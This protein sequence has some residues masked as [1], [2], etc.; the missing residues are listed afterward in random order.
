MSATTDRL[1]E[2]ERLRDG[3]PLP[4]PHLNGGELVYEPS[5]EP[6]WEDGE[7]I[8]RRSESSLKVLDWHALLAE[9][10]EP[11]PMLDEAIP[12]SKVGL[13]VL[14]GPP[15]VGKTLWASQAALTVDRTT[16]VVEEGSLAG[17]SWRLR[18]QAAAL[19][20][21]AP[22]LEVIHR[23]GIRL[24]DRHTVERLRRHV[25]ARRPRLL[26][27]DPLN[28]LHRADENRPT[29]MTPVMDALAAIA[30]DFDCAVLAVHH[31]AKPSQERRGDIWD[32][33]RG[34]TSIRSG[35][36]CNLVLDG[37]GELLHLVGEYRDAEPLNQ[38]VELDR[39]TLTFRPVEGPKAVTKV[40]PDALRAYVL[41]RGQATV[42]EVAERF[43]VVRHTARAAL[44]S[45][46]GIDSFEGPR[47]A[48]YYTFGTGQ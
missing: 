4:L 14:A 22:D 11:P 39:E 31:L 28:R 2:Y 38:Y 32:R 1:L 42:T 7:A 41:E 25:A 17:V 24:D 8:G 9:P 47:S 29:Q 3:D 36:D 13:T 34:A 20:V 5:P 10:P 37:S 12:I 48:R 23:Q 44:E 46:A 30:Y 27:M 35:T 45:L 21:S 26:V 33:F 43:G 19:S 18:K 40:D 6:P 16:I 15:K